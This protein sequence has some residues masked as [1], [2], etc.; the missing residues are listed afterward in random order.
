MQIRYVLVNEDKQTLFLGM[1]QGA[2][3]FTDD[4][5]FIEEHGITKVASFPSLKHAIEFANSVRI[6]KGVGD[7]LTAH[8]VTCEGNH[9]DIM[10]LIRQ[11]F[12]KNS[13][14]LLLALP[15]FNNTI[16]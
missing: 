4:E 9:V 8:A 3:Y 2:V 15:A 5:D 6:V 10:E 11:G 14:G 16:H 12:S 13:A 7:T 1:N